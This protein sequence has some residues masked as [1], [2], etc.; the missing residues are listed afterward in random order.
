MKTVR[1]W[2]GGGLLAAL[3]LVAFAV[4]AAH[5]AHPPPRQYY[6]SYRHHPTRRYYYRSYYYKPYASYS[7]YRHHYC[8]HVPSRPNYVYYYDPQQR[9]YWGRYDL[10]AKGYSLLAKKDRREKLGAIPEDAFP[11]PEK[12]MP[13]IP[14]SDD[15]QTVLTPPANDLPSGKPPADAPQ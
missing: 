9:V 12:K 8:V 13:P 5:A 15:G 1:S 14:E 7:G 11:Q 10:Q 2:G 4:G 6:S 3:L